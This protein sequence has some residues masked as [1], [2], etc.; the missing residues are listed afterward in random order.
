MNTANTD[1]TQS[2]RTTDRLAGS[3]HEAID[4]AAAGLSSTER[5]VRATAGEMNDALHTASHKTRL[6]AKRTLTSLRDYANQ[7]PITTLG[8]AFVAGLVLANFKRLT[9]H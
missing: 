7:Y 2:S 4:K 6:Q 8:I 9:R 3:A 5:H 1:H